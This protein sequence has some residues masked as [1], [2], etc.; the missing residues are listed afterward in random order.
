MR[1]QK[2][3]L[4][5]REKAM[6]GEFDDVDED[7]VA[8]A[9][10]VLVI[11]RDRLA[12]ARKRTR[13]ALEDVA[14]TESLWAIERRRFREATARLTELCTRIKQLDEALEDLPGLEE[15]LRADDELA[16][17][18]S[19]SAQRAVAADAAGVRAALDPVRALLSDVDERLRR[20]L[21]TR[22]QF[23]DHAQRIISY[24]DEIL[25]THTDERF[26]D[27]QS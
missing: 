8:T 23:D 9:D 12:E 18:L 1:E 6:A 24:A 14:E 5:E 15:Y 20:M 4:S 11:G 22:D 17:A 16:E 2:R 25:D 13:Q 3:L 26:G 21:R 19:R 27:D 7:L 10:R